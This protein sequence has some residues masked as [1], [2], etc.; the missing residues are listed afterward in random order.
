MR[1]IND[2][3]LGLSVPTNHTRIDRRQPMQLKIIKFIPIR[4][5]ASIEFVSNM[6]G[7]KRRLADV[8][9]IHTILAEFV[10]ELH[11]RVVYFGGGPQR[12]P[13]P[14]WVLHDELGVGVGG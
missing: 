6:I 1:H 7:E 14:Q 8:R 13:I 5:N 4:H 12:H 11:D 10:I 3:P 2:I 9:D